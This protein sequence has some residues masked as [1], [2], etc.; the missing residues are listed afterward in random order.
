[1]RLSGGKSGSARTLGLAF[2]AMAAV[3]V[4]MVLALS[5]LIVFVQDR[6]AI[7][8]SVKIV[9]GN[10]QN[11][12]GEMSLLVKEYGYW[13]QAVE[14]IVRNFDAE[15]IDSQMGEYLFENADVDLIRVVDGQNR[16]VLQ[17]REGVIE[18][19]SSDPTPG[20]RALL[21]AA[22]ATED[23]TEPAAV[24]GYVN[25]ED[26]YFM[27]GALR[28]TTYQG[29]D[30]YSTDHVMIFMRRID[31]ELIAELQASSLVKDLRWQLGNVGDGE[32]A[33]ALQVM[34]E[35]DAKLV[36]R[37]DLPGSQMIPWLLSG[38]LGFV[39]VILLI[40][41]IFMRRMGANAIDLA[42]AR[43][44]AELANRT[45]SDF[46]AGMSHELRTPLNAILGFAQLMREQLLGPVG[47]PRYLE[48]AAD[49]HQAGSHLLSLVNGLLD[50][51]KIEA[52]RF[53]LEIADVSFA[54]VAGQSLTLVEHLA[55][56]K[57]IVLEVRPEAD[58]TLRADARALRQIL[59]NLLNNAL[60]FTP[61]GGRVTLQARPAAAGKIE[62][63]VRDT[64]IGIKPSD[65]PLI[66]EPF[67]QVKSDV[68]AA[69]RGTGLGLPLARKL[70]EMMQGDL[71]IESGRDTGTT[72]T[73]TLPAAA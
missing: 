36:W 25:V 47:N 3:S 1:M 21:N 70:A 19:S 68:N 37:P 32:A 16:I 55:G 52:G 62:I 72:V 56:E 23:D 60:K 10:L 69:Y 67:T 42:R 14:N 46:L 31:A 64:G 2:G 45:K 13:D 50:L 5:F 54:E 59:V 6:N 7:R 29:D 34:N 8:A 61:E 66:L 4:L 65:I 58:L 20:E 44:E 49:I 38:I 18:E 9:G 24:R 41:V 53:D 26:S 27:T 33:I 71:R 48:Y 39:V 57:G 28:M 40:G 22:R 30:D 17:I 35:P 51:S 73:V 11:R 63:T 43:E 15:W 12:L